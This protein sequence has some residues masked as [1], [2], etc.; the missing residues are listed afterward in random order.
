MVADDALQAAEVPMQ[1]HPL[2]QILTTADDAVAEQ[3]AA[4]AERQRAGLVQADPEDLYA[5]GRPFRLHIRLHSSG[6]SSNVR[7]PQTR[8]PSLL[9]PA[10]FVTVSS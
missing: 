6:T 5:G 3:L 9:P 8:F 10:R 7:R 4:L 1:H 2:E